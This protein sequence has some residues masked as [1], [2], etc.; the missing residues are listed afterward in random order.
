MHSSIHICSERGR[1]ISALNA[2]LD[3]PAGEEE[4]TR[5]D[6]AGILGSLI[7]EPRCGNTPAPAPASA[8]ARDALRHLMARQRVAASALP[9]IGDEGRVLEVLAGER[10]LTAAQIV[11]LARRFGVSRALFL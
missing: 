2:L 4:H 8:C 11:A 9:E 5:A 3:A 1:L 6:L 10:A 7:A